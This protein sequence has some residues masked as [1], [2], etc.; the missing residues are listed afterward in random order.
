M[1]QYGGAGAGV[2]LGLGSGVFPIQA[3]SET[4]DF[5]NTQS[6]KG[7]PITGQDPGL[8]LQPIASSI[9]DAWTSKAG[10]GGDIGSDGLGGYE[11]YESG[12]SIKYRNT[13][14]GLAGKA[15]EGNANINWVAAGTIIG[16]IE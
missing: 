14:G 9:G 4:I 6:F 13:Y 1:N 3:T 10:M 11:P 2:P 12:G 7:L 15:I 8:Y 5:I 16:A